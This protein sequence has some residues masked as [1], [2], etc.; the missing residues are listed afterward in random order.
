MTT[1]HL[2]S[3]GLAGLAV[4]GL[5]AAGVLGAVAGPASA[6]TGTTAGASGSAA[7]AS[8]GAQASPA[9]AGCTPTV[10]A[11]G[12]A[13]MGQELAARVSE[14]GSLQQAVAKAKRL[15]TS[16]RATLTT[17]LQNETTGI[18]ALQQKV[19][20][21]TTCAQVVADAKAMVV[22]FRV[23]VVMAP[24][25]H[26]T[27]AADTETGVAGIFQGLEPKIQAAIT[28]AKRAGRN[29]VQAQAD[30]AAY[31]L[32]VIG[33]QN[34]ASGIAQ[35]VL[36][37]TPASYPGCRSTFQKDQTSL[38]RGSEALHHADTELHL[39]IQALR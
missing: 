22:N 21:D 7:G 8:G 12:K 30:F 15:T 19:P 1:R 18:T 32:L 39:I 13:K 14:L 5:A 37:F 20:G 4:S 31:K 23:Y 26:L 34:S 2:I 17:D 28:A 16:D 25:V 10:L 29:V 35:S 27:V 3:R 6:A 33:A 11:M 36:S 24:Q 38:H 9:S